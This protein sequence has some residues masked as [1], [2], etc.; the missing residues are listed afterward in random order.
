MANIAKSVSNH[1][2]YR[3]GNTK[4]QSS[5]LILGGGEEIFVKHACALIVMRFRQKASVGQV[6]MFGLFKKGK[7]CE[8]LSHIFQLRGKTGHTRKESEVG[9]L[10]QKDDAMT[11]EF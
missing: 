3:V 5:P 9:K 11:L 1:L 2:R 7:K 4:R 8:R 6:P 10:H